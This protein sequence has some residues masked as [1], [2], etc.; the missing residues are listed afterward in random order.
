MLLSD[1]KEYFGKSAHVK[2][3][4]KKSVFPKKFPVPRKYGFLG[5]TLFRCS[6]SEIFLQ[7]S[8][9]HEFL[10]FWHKNT[11]S[12]TQKQRLKKYTVFYFDLKIPIPI[13]NAWTIC[14][15]IKG[16]NHG[17]LIYICT[18][19]YTVSSTCVYVLHERM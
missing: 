14:T 3:W 5:P 10:I 19:I 1:L 11:K 13:L 17:T 16:Q 9:Q 4:S 8:N 15:F 2:K 18:T 6:F 7:I 12:A